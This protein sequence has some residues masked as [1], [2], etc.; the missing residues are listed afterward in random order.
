M[1]GGRLGFSGMDEFAGKVAVVTGA[2]SGIG[3]ALA[4]RWAGLDMK[5]ALADIEAEPLDEVAEALRA[6]GTDVLAVPTD[7]SDGD[8]VDAFARATLDEYGAMHLLCNNAGVGGGGPMWTL[9]EADWRWVLGVNLWGVIHGI[10]AFVPHLVAQGEGYVVN[11]ASVAGLSSPPMLGPYNASKHAVVT[12]SETLRA[13]LGMLAD[14]DFGVTVVCPGWVRTRIA[15]SE[16]NR[17]DEL[18]NPETEDS[19]SRDEVAG[20]LDSALETGMEPEE[21]AEMVEQAVRDER[22]YVLTVDDW[23]P[24]LRER[25]ETFVAEVDPPGAAAGASSPD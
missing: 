7:V 23:T 18:R 9:T 16:R 5:L 8:Q 2:A 11:T 22:L 15:D 10:R 25:L 4:E 17:P 21:L 13:E 20:A 6:G 19:P 24:M 12:I 3:R 1:P 14:G